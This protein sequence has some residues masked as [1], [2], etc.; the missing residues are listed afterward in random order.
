MYTINKKN[1]KI[2]VSNAKCPVQ[3][4]KIVFFPSK[5]MDDYFYIRVFGPSNIN[6]VFPLC[7]LFGQ[8]EIR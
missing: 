1:H 6:I 4:Y 3:N 5:N 7:Y 8:L 2:V